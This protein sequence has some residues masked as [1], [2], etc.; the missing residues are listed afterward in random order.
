MAYGPTG[1]P[2]FV[3]PRANMYAARCVLGYIVWM[4]SIIK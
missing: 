2:A 3:R 1:F 4:C